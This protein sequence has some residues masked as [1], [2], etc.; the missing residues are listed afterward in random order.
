MGREPK[1]RGSRQAISLHGGGVARRDRL[2]PPTGHL[3][4]S[5]LSSG[6]RRSPGARLLLAF[7]RKRKRAHGERGFSSTP[8]DEDPRDT[9]S[10]WAWRS[11]ATGDEEVDSGRTTAGRAARGRIRDHRR[12]RALRPLRRDPPLGAGRAGDPAPNGLGAVRWIWLGP[13]RFEEEITAF[14]PPRRLDYL[15]RDVRILP[16]ATRAAAS[17]SRPTAPARM[18]CGRPRSRSRSR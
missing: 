17:G 14:E 11:R 18:R 4:G 2:G 8:L 6:D 3:R 10:A 5:G 7:T 15:I 12:P 16:S 9:L 13:L 1:R